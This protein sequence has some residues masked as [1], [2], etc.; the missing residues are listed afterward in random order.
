M[1]GQG[2]TLI[3]RRSR[4]GDLLRSAR[5]KIWVLARGVWQS[6]Q[7]GGVEWVHPLLILHVF[8]AGYSALVG[9]PTFEPHFRG[10]VAAS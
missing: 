2:E 3:S 7:V 1:C 6:M 4:L 5:A 9:I 8:W 10:S